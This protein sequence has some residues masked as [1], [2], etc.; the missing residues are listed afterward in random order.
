MS[1]IQTTEMDG[2]TKLINVMQFRIL[3]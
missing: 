1:H 3:F 2:G